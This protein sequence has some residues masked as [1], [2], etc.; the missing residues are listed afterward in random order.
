M[1]SAKSLSYH[2]SVS[3]T[4]LSYSIFP[5]TPEYGV[6]RQGNPVAGGRGMEDAGGAGGEEEST[7]VVG[8]RP[9]ERTAP[10][11]GQITEAA[12]YD[13]IWLAKEA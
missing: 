4:Y 12:R 7:F 13:R 6:D 3:L 5:L 8:R 10:T 9:A 2:K 1:R 11:R